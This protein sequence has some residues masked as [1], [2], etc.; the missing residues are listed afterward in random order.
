MNYCLVLAESF[1]RN[2]LIPNM[3]SHAYILFPALYVCKVLKKKN[4][5][6]WTAFHVELKVK[7]T[8]TKPEQWR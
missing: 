2:T 7:F 3:I 1:W 6:I 5:G 4:E 8:F